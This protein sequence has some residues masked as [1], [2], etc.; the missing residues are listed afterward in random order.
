MKLKEWLEQVPT[1]PPGII[2]NFDRL[3]IEMVRENGLETMMSR[4]AWAKYVAGRVHLLHML[5]EHG[6][7]EDLQEVYGD[8]SDCREDIK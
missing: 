2:T 5:L 8:G 7:P 3:V 6:M 4:E 1:S